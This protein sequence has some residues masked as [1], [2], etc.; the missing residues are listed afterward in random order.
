MCA[1]ELSEIEVSIPAVWVY[2]SIKTGYVWEVY[3]QDDTYQ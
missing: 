3:V 1:T 2:I